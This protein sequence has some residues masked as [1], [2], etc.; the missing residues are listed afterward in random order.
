MLPSVNVLML[1]EGE[2]TAVAVKF[3]VK[4]EVVS[5][6]EID[7]GGLKSGL[8]VKVLE[9]IVKSHDVPEVVFSCTR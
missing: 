5:G 2:I 4:F 7:T 1:Q 8:A 6:N 9:N 3:F